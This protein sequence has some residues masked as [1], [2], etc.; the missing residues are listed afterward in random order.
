MAVG[1]TVPILAHAGSDQ[2]VYFVQPVEG[3]TVGRTVKVVMGVSGM[4][5]QPAGEVVEGS[6]H[7]HLIIDGGPIAKGEAVPKDGRHLHFGKGQ[8]QTTI[9]LS[10]GA[11]TLTLQFADGQHHSFGPAMSKTIHVTVE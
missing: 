3:A 2:G 5:V 8:T 7:H 10:P 6:G 1:I 4:R 9:E 11:H